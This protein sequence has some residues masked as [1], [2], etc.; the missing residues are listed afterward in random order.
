MAVPCTTSSRCWAPWRD[1]H[2]AAGT[3]AG[4]GVLPEQPERRMVLP[5]P[6]FT[7]VGE[8]DLIPAAEEGMGEPRP[9]PLRDGVGSGE[10][11]HA[12]RR[13]ERPHGGEVGILRDDVLPDGAP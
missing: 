5:V 9:C 12:L 13:Q 10:V 3:E 2:W 4:A 7:A 8:P 1:R 6:L 11:V